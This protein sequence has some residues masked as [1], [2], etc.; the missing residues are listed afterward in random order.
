MADRTE[1]M[2]M[3]RNVMTAA[4]ML[5]C[6]LLGT[7]CSAE[8]KPP[9][10]PG[11]G[12]VIIGGADFTTADFLRAASEQMGAEYQLGQELQQKLALFWYDK[13]FVEDQTKMSKDEMIE[14]A[15]YSGLDRIIY[16]TTGTPVVE[17]SKDIWVGSIIRTSMN[18]RVIVMEADGT[19]V[20]L[21]SASQNGDSRSSEM[22]AKRDC[23]KK[24][25]R[26]IRNH[27]EEN[28]SGTKK[29]A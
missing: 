14:F 1:A 6:L 23:F 17:Q 3:K 26:E 15:K 25:M 18:A 9:I 7:V 29:A 16:V 19:M 20:D 13:G 4:I 2:D 12:V 27:I 21:F 24:V 11:V 5:L 22:R 28:K 10:Q 8:E